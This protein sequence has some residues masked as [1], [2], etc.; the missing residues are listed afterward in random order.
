M[1][2]E[3]GGPGGG[4]GIEDPE[5]VAVGVPVEETPVLTSLRACAASMPWGFHMTPLGWCCLIY[6]T[7]ER[8]TL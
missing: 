3:G 2:P 8:M 4:G 5:G 7:S 6:A 1:A